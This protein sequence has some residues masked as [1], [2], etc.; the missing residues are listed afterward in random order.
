MDR[1]HHGPHGGTCPRVDGPECS[2]YGADA[3]TRYGV[4]I[5]L[6]AAARYV[7]MCQVGDEKWYPPDKGCLTVADDEFGCRFGPP[8]PGRW[9]TLRVL[10]LFA[11][12][13]VSRH[14]PG[15]P[16]EDGCKP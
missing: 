14:G 4:L 7:A 11:R 2:R 15:V 9:A 10:F 8:D 12:L 1:W 3:V 6:L 16:N 5:G 13:A